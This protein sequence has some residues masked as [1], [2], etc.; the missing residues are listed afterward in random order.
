M[1][2]RSCTI[3]RIFEQKEIISLKDFEM[4]TAAQAYVNMDKDKDAKDFLTTDEML[5]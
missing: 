4:Q 2:C 1:G 3:S 5:D